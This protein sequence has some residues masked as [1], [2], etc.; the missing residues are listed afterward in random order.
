[1]NKLK[2]KVNKVSESQNSFVGRPKSE[3]T[4]TMILNGQQLSQEQEKQD[5]EN[6]LLSEFAALEQQCRLHNTF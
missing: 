1:M 3:S 5:P 4:E 6:V 2:V